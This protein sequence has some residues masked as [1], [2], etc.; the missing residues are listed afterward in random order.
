MRT[1]EEEVALG[2]R[3]QRAYDVYLKDF[4]ELNYKELF[5][6]FVDCTND[7]D[8]QAIRRLTHANRELQM[9]LERD[10]DSGKMAT[11]TLQQ[12]KDKEA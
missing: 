3:A 1:L 7:E 2:Q 8:A 11:I 9:T 4:F 5:A 6:A 12:A 10:I